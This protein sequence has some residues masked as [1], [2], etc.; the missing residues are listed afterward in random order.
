MAITGSGFTLIVKLIG[1]PPHD[2]FSVTVMVALIVDPVLFVP[3]TKSLMSPDPLAARPMAVLLLVQ[4]TDAPVFTLKAPTL[5]VSPGHTLMFDFCE[6]ILSGLM[7]ITNTSAALVH[8]SLL[9]R[10]LIVPLIADP[11]LFDGAVNMMSPLPVAEIPIAV[12]VLVHDK[13][14]PLTLLDNGMLTLDPGQKL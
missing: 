4:V 7:V 12:F 9:A 1:E 6:I 3:A 8:P 13:V 5:I 14:D 2:A 10:T 11:V